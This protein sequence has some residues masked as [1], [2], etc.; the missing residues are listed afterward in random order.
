MALRPTA[1]R[2]AAMAI[3]VVSLAACD[4]S[5]PT[6]VTRPMGARASLIT[7][8]TTP[9]L[10]PLYQQTATEAYQRLCFAGYTCADD[11]VV[12]IGET[13]TITDVALTGTGGGTAAVPTQVQF[14]RDAGGLPGTVIL[15]FSVPPIS[16]TPEPSPLIFNYFR[17][18]PAPLVLT[19]G[20]YWLGARDFGWAVVK[21][22]VNNWATFNLGGEPWFRL[23]AEDLAFRLYTR[24]TPSS[25]LE[26][27]QRSITGLGLSDGIT[28]SL[29][30][31]LRAALLALASDDPA[32]ACDALQALLNHVRAQ[33]AKHIPMGDADAI[34]ATVITIRGQ[35]GC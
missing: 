12:P 8:A 4:A 11:F 33:R 27:L 18:L 28:K 6:A 10:V 23:P 9:T 15:S 17:A 16:S 13:W 14:Y 35:I 31:K 3:M 2:I 24:Q 1:E 21:P 7:A 29:D 25:A 30:A 19:A 20:T 32:T 34:T 26:A 5:A 22:V